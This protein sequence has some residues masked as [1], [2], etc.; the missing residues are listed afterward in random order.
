M[1]NY[2]YPPLGGGGGVINQQFAEELAGRLPVTVLT[3]GRAGLPRDERKGDL[4]IHR[5]P[6]LMRSADAVA[7]H[8]S[9]L[10]FFPSSLWYGRR[11]M[12][13]EPVDI[14]HS[15]FAIPSAPSGLLLARWAGCPHVLS[16]LGGD[17]YDPSKKLSPHRTPILKQTVRAMVHR[18]DRV[19]AES[20]DIADR[21]RM[22][23]DA[24]EVDRIP[25]ALHPFPYT[26]ISRRELNPDF[27][28]DSILL[29]TVGRLVSRKRVDDLIDA[30]AHIDDERVRLIVVG[31]GPMRGELEAQARDRGVEDR[32]SFAGFVSEERKWQLL[33]ASDVYVSATSHEGFGIS[34]LEAMEAGL[35]VVSHDCGGHVD[36]LNEEVSFLVELG[37]SLGL[38]EKITRICGDFALRT[39]MGAAA[40]DEAKKFHIDAFA[41]RYLDLYRECLEE[42]ARA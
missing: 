15:F 25:L 10:S 7:S 5:I 17:I 30:V 23:Y 20:R 38:R 2:E 11:I 21:T 31:D 33:A 8:V 32:V 16:V 9:M 29:I 24:P 12:A 37:N 4:R 40:R 27:S 6:V 14:V 41:D 22:I 34:F 28:D 36:F 42:R 18:S 19:V 1:V 3:S 39:R 26:K 13:T 35:P